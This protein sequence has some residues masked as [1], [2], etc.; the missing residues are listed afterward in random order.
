MV[1]VHVQIMS[2][3]P[4]VFGWL[5]HPVTKALE[6]LADDSG[7]LFKRV[8]LESGDRKFLYGC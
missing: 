2:R 6:L 3:V 1:T 7:D 5:I 8:G 4:L